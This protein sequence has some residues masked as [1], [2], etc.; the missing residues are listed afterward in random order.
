VKTKERIADLTRQ[1]VLVLCCLDYSWL[2]EWNVYLAAFVRI[3]YTRI[4]P[5]PTYPG[6]KLTLEVCLTRD[7]PEMITAKRAYEL[8]TLMML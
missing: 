3:L 6:G 4:F 2:H 7:E 1:R 5:T 8:S